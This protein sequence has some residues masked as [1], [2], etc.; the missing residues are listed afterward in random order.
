MKIK[1]LPAL[2]MLSAGAITSIIMFVN[3]FEVHRF[4]YTLFFVLLSFFLMG[5][6]LTYCIEKFTRQN[7]EAEKEAI[8][9]EALRQH[10]LLQ[11]IDMDDAFADGSVH[12]KTL[13]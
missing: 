8:M 7:E 4:V 13:M 6:L 11:N 3:H 12:Q 2:I 10:E 1:N 5:S 9:Q